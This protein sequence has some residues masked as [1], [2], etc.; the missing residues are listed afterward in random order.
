MWTS[1]YLPFFS[2]I[3][4]LTTS[5]QRILMIGMRFLFASGYTVSLLNY[6]CRLGILTDE[7]HKAELVTETGARCDNNAV[8]LIADLYWSCLAF[9]FCHKFAHIYLKHAAYP[10]ENLNGFW[11]QEYE[12]DAIGYD[13]YLQ[14][15]EAVR[16]HPDEPFEKVF[17][18]YLYIAPM[19]LFQFYED[20]Y[21]MGYWLFGERTGDSHLPLRDRPNA[22]LRLSESDKYTFETREGNIVLN[23]YMDISDCFREQLL[24]KL[25]KGKLNSLL[26]EGVAFMEA[27][28][29]T[30]ALEFQKSMCEKLKE[31]AQ[32]LGVDKDLLV[33]LWDTAVDIEILDLLRK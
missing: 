23:N 5:G 3:L 4:R 22:L 21:Y 11:D 7:V 2:S 17:H 12:A 20:T 14:I 33:G 19:V 6:S 30:E 9:A 10:P 18:D 32:L 24:L 25:R 26:Q 8:N 13:V 29:Y 1:W 27:P 16:S 28:G 31:N 15:I